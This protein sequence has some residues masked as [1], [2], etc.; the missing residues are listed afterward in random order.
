MNIELSKVEQ[1]D[2]FPVIKMSINHHRYSFT[3]KDYPKEHWPWLCDMFD[4]NIQAAYRQGH[5]AGIKS[6]Q[7]P[8]RKALDFLLEKA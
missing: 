8:I 4:R 2:S 1:D 3:I 5:V 7:E 6:V